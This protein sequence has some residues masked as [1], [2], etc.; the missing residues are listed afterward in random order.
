MYFLAAKV[1]RSYL[2][3]SYFCETLGFVLTGT[4]FSGESK[5]L[6]LSTRSEELANFLSPPTDHNN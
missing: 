3:K 2:R 6:T 5:S 4:V 1:T